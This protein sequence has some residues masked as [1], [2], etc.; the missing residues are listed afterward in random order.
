MQY[1]H[2]K[3]EQAFD[4]LE[5]AVALAKENGYEHERVFYETL[6]ERL[7]GLREE[8]RRSL[9][10]LGIKNAAPVTPTTGTAKGDSDNESTISLEEEAQNVKGQGGKTK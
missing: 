7:I 8:S 1:M 4:H 3:V 2:Y 9:P 10:D 6:L 5:E